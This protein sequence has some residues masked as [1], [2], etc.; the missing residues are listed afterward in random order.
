MTG[1]RAET[2]KALKLEPAFSRNRS[3]VQQKR[4]EIE[5]KRT[6]SL[7]DRL[8]SQHNSHRSLRP[9]RKS[10]SL[11]V[12]KQGHTTTTQTAKTLAREQSITK[13]SVS[14]AGPY[15]LPGPSTGAIPKR[16]EQE[17][18]SKRTEEKNEKRKRLSETKNETHGADPIPLP[19]PPAPSDPTAAAACPA[20]FQINIPGVARI[21]IPNPPPPEF[22]DPRV[23]MLPE[24]TPNPQD[25]RYWTFQDLQ[26]YMA[27]RKFMI[28]ERLRFFRIIKLTLITLIKSF[29]CIGAIICLYSKGAEWGSFSSTKLFEVEHE[30]D[31]MLPDISGCIHVTRLRIP[32][33]FPPESKFVNTIDCIPKEA[34]K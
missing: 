12:W 34:V 23:R 30:F 28:E 10:G 9:Q 13:E 25:V 20:R 14:V 32:K 31:V 1:K 11:K 29:F 5:G 22:H 7:P 21:S 2:R 15:S 8:N 17:K 19:P 27:H 24:G 4:G 6:V 33:N 3:Q 26:L 16:R 18:E